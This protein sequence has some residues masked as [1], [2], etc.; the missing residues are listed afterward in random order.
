M[1]VCIH[2]KYILLNLSL[3]F[4][5]V[6]MLCYSSAAH[7]DGETENTEKRVITYEIEKDFRNI[8]K[9]DEKIAYLTFDDGPSKY[10]TCKVLDV[11]E[12][13]D[14]KATFFVLR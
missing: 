8:Y 10:T 7:F 3:I 12:R 6:F 13:F 9:S 4:L 2:K 5:L 14:I 11:L 1:W